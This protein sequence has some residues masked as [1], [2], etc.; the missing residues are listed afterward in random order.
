MHRI[1][2]NNIFNANCSNHSREIDVYSLTNKSRKKKFNVNSLIEKNKNRQSKIHSFYKK[3]L[4][5]C[6]EKIT[7]ANSYRKTEIIFKVP[8]II[9]G[10]YNYNSMECLDFINKKL[11]EMKFDTII[12]NDNSIYISWSNIEEKIKN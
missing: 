2:I 6:L 4:D 3:K 5:L 12:L 11:T 1:S 10:P 7:T 9:I 8:R